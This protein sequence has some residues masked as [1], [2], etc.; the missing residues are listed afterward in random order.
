M[1][2]ERKKLFLN[3]FNFITNNTFAD[4]ISVYYVLNFTVFVKST[5]VAGSEIIQFKITSD[6]KRDELN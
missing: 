2:K 4:E 3:W 1:K 6:L 5:D